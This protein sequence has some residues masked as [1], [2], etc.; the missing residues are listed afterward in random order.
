MIQGVRRI[1]GV[2]V[3]CCALLLFCAALAADVEDSIVKSFTVRQGGTLILRS[4][5]G[6]VEVSRGAENVVRVEV[7]RKADGW[8][9]SRAEERL[10]DF[11][12]DFNQSGDQIS[13]NGEGPQSHWWMFWRRNNIKVRFLITVP[14]KYN[15]DLKTG[16]GSIRVSDLDGRV[17]AR[18]SGGSL[19]FGRINGN[20]E[21]YTSGG[22][23][24]VD[25]ASGY[26]KV[27]TSG[28]SIR[29]GRVDGTVDAETSGGSIR[30]EEVAGAVRAD[31]SG[32]SI[33]A[34]ISRQPKDKCSLTTSGGG[35]TVELERNIGVYLDAS[36]SGG[37][38]SVDLPVTVSGEIRRSHVRGKINGGGP[39]LYL[40]T[41]GGSVRV[42]TL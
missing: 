5:Q 13:I 9:R 3:F 30:I 12:V 31:T 2:A 10:R 24:T 35:I 21:G 11:R 17:I 33:H 39:E 28:G 26:V 32:G 40:H 4:T 19:S 23:I 15:L 42:S 1:S 6:S 38:V 20:L 27:D 34:R 22:S 16:G 7:W 41:S 37:S 14:A 18:T 36:T 8:S 25:G 29:I